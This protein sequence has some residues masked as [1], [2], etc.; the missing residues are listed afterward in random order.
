MTTF[1][2]VGTSVSK[3]LLCRIQKKILIKLSNVK[4]NWKEIIQAL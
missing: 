3:C 4:L 2:L 1:W